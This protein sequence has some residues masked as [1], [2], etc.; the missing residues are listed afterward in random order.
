MAKTTKGF[1]STAH[2]KAV[3]ENEPDLGRAIASKHGA[4]VGGGFT[5]AQ[6]QRRRSSAGKGETYQP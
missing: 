4:K 3:F 1:K 6:L 2:R 5:K